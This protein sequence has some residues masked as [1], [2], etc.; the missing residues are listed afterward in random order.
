M[1]H[2]IERIAQTANLQE[3]FLRAARG[4][5]CTQAVLRFRD[6]LHP[7]LEA[8]ASELLDGSYRFGPYRFFIVFDP[9]RRMICAAPF[10]DRVTMH[11]MMRIC[12]PVLDAY[13]TADSYASRV[14]RGTYAALE[15]A[16][17]LAQR[18][19]WWAKLDV[20]K[21]FDSI[22]HGVLMRQLCRLFKDGVLLRL[23][24]DQLDGYHTTPGRG[25]PIGNLTSQY[26]ANHYLALADHH[27]RE[28]LHVPGMVRYMDDVLLFDSDRH[29]LND[30][31]ARYS[32]YAT[33]E[34]ALEMH[35][36]VINSSNQGIPFLG[37]VVRPSGLR[38]N[39]RSRKRFITKMARWAA[40]LRQ[41]LVSEQEYVNHVTCLMAFVDKADVRDLKHK[42]STIPG[43]YPQG[44]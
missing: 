1:G 43:M 5:G 11:A 37:Y 12:H 7:E 9:K 2:L 4:K 41:G 16:R 18:Y 21:Y 30:L 38:L 27:A 15:R 6:N 39:A 20:C 14:G 8:I 33:H 35:D 19:Q 17:R 22:D 28:R 36:P 29:R 40:W 26:F 23:W 25:L 42:L 13:Q 3:A 34:L 10:R 32:A 44:L 31:V 24:A